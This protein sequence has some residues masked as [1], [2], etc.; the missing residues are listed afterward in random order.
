MH[1]FI[2]GVNMSFSG[3]LTLEPSYDKLKT[4]R[5]LHLEIYDK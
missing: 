2:T 3:I 5:A 4:S 1:V